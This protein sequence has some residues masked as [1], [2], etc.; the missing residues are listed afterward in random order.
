[1]KKYLFKIYA[2]IVILFFGYLAVALTKFVANSSQSTYFDTVATFVVIFGVP[3]ML[4][5]WFPMR[6]Y[7]RF[8]KKNKKRDE[9]D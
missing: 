9:D 3:M 4:L 8:K 6:F 5:I 1:M 7:C 2:I